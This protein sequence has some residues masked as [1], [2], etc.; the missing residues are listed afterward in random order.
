MAKRRYGRNGS[1]RWLDDKG[2]NHRE[3]GPAVV[4]ADG[5]QYW[6]RHGRSHFAYGPAV[7]Y[8]DG[9]LVWYEAGHLLRGRKPYG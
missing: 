3:D 8:D 2:Y 7:L 5:T 1:V 6:A 4:Y 9:R